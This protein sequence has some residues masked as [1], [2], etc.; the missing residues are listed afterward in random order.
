MNRSSIKKGFCLAATPFLVGV[1]LLF[2]SLI[3]GGAAPA[4]Q[5]SEFSSTDWTG[6]AYSSD[7]TGSFSHCAASGDYKSGITMFV[8]VSRDYSWSLGFA[9]PD[10][11]LTKGKKIP[12]KFRIDRGPWLEAIANAIDSKFVGIPM[13]GEETLVSLFRF[14]RRMQVYDYY[15]HFYFDLDGTNKLLQDLASCVEYQLS[16]EKQPQD[17]PTEPTSGSQSEQPTERKLS[18]GSG[19][20]VSATGK[21]VTNSHVV[22]DCNG[23]IVQRSGGLPTTAQAIADDAAN[24]LALLQSELK[25]SE[26]EIASINV[27]RPVRAGESIAVFGFPMVGTL[28]TTGN[29]VSGNITSLTGLGD[30]VRFF[31]IS[32]PIQPGNSGGPLL[33]EF[34]NVIGVVN[35][36]LNE[37]AWAKETGEWPQNVNFAIKSSVLSSFLGAHSTVFQSGSTSV[38]QDLPTRTE[39]AQKFTVMII[40]VH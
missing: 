35:S 17:P 19:I 23:L 8:A 29:V 1:A 14:G 3:E 38:K 30:D 25:I 36:K 21:I 4:R 13:A 26:D 34:G 40:C 20:I 6:G 32:A 7:A 28:S 5:I 15:N 11:K 12:L 2:L 37:I 9:H 31:Q 22:K 16:M 24:D 33:D 18:S 39:L 27:T 10:W